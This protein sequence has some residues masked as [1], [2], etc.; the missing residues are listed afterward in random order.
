MKLSDKLLSGLTGA[1]TLT[2]IHETVRTNQSNAPRMDLLGKQSLVKIVSAMG[3]QPPR[4]P[5]TL[6]TITLAGDILANTLYYSF[7]PTSSEKKLWKRC[8]GLGILAG[9]GAVVLPKHLGLSSEASNR[10]SK[11]QVLTVMLYS[12]GAL[13]TALTSL[14]LSDKGRNI[15]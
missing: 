3:V 2:L 7:I 6:H 11:T 13:V 15:V 10:T 4:N 9:A 14:I 5:S 8:A 12:T 1:L